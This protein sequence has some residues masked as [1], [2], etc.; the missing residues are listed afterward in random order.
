MSLAAAA[1]ELGCDLGAL[2]RAARAFTA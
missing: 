2:Q 1:L